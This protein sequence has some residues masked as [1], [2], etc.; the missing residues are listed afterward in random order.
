MILA[1]TPPGNPAR[2]ESPPARIPSE[3]LDF[4]RGAA[5]VYVLI[6]H[7]RGAFFAG[8]QRIIESGHHSLWDLGAIAAL[9]LTSLGSES[10]VLFFVVSGFAMAN[11]VRYSP[12]VGRFYLK[13]FVRIWPPYVAAIGVAFSICAFMI[14]YAPNHA[15]SQRCAQ[16]ICSP[17]RILQMLVYVNPSTAITPQFWSLPYEIVFYVVC[18]FLLA[19]GSRII[20][21]FATSVVF[22]VASAF[23]F[24]VELN[25]AG[26]FA[27]N[28]LVNELLFFMAGVMTFHFLD[29]IPTIRPKWL[30]VWTVLLLAGMLGIK[31]LL[32]FSNL[33][34]N[35]CM[36]ALAVLLIRNLPLNIAKYKP[37]NWGF[38][39]YSIYIF[40]F[41]FV[42]LGS[43]FV[44]VRYGLTQDKM[45][46]YWGWILTVPPIL[47]FCWLLYNVTEKYS[48]L[49]VG[50]LRAREHTKFSATSN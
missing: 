28:F 38:F 13:R 9:Q 11:S 42:A 30:A 4:L 32:G 34:S 19:G 24:G 47:L 29:R 20:L 48:N 26:N 41:S 14:Y 36:I 33:P 49:A 44:D 12:D 21:V 22:C 15:I 27:G 43:F 16:E 6:N 35:F 31:L 18:P 10:V 50:R 37:T 40:H 46:S 5:A 7:A 1:N 39:S 3:V 23:V 45:T 2:R 25:P 8:G 17:V